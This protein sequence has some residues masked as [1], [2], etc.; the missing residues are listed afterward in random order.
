MWKQENLIDSECLIVALTSYNADN[1]KADTF[2]FASL[3]HGSDFAAV[4]L[5]DLDNA[6]YTKGIDGVGATH[7]EVIAYLAPL[8]SRYKRML[9]IGDSMG[10]FGAIL[11]GA[12]V[13]ADKIVAISPQTSVCTRTCNILADGRFTRFFE[14][15]SDVPATIKDV[16]TILAEWPAKSVDVYVSR[17]DPLDIENARNIQSIQN[18]NIQYVDHFDHWMAEE[19]KRYGA[20]RSIIR[21]FLL[22]RGSFD[23]NEFIAAERKALGSSLSWLGDGTTNENETLHERQLA[24]EPNWHLRERITTGEVAFQSVVFGPDAPTY[25]TRY[26]HFNDEVEQIKPDFLRLP[27]A[28]PIAGAATGVNTVLT[29]ALIKEKPVSNLGIP[30]LRAHFNVARSGSEAEGQQGEELLQRMDFPGETT[31]PHFDPKRHGHI[32][33]GPYVRLEAGTYVAH[34][35]LA[36]DFMTDTTLYLDL[37]CDCGRVVVVREYPAQ[38]LRTERWL[39]VPFHLHRA[40]GDIEVRLRTEKGASGSVNNVFINR[41]A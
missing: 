29:H 36:D 19:L 10:A 7:E 13:K 1:S 31:R 16:R 39:K 20:L 5:K 38:L 32:M 3:T 15:L 4:L 2:D 28:L 12:R 6:W 41:V 9:F 33:S 8:R 30:S 37:A 11:L 34:V 14:K 24:I 25:V 21:N 23:L 26:F 35:K 40:K 22:D 18:V 27:I 17:A